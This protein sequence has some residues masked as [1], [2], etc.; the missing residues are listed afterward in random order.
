MKISEK[1]EDLLF[2]I[3]D[4]D[5]SDVNIGDDEDEILRFQI[6]LHGRTKDNRT[7]YVR[8]DDYTPYFYIEIPSQWRESHVNFFM[9]ALKKKV[10]Y[11][12]RCG[13][14]S[15][16]TVT[17]YKFVGFTNNKRFNFI[18]LMFHSY[19][20]FRSYGY[21]LNKPIFH[22][23]LGKK[24]KKYKAYESNVEPMLRCMHIQNLEAAGWV[25]IKG[26]NYK[27]FENN[28]TINNVN[29]NTKYY[30][31]NPYKDN[32]ILPLVIASFDIECTSGDG[33]FPQAWR[34]S[35]KI[36]QIGTT[37]SRYGESECFYRHIITLGSC[38]P[39]P[40][41]DVESYKTEGEVLLAW[42]KMIKKTNPDILTGYNIF[43]FDYK[44][45]RDRSKKLGVEYRFSKLCRD[46][47]SI[48]PF[49]TKELSSAAMGNNE[50]T[51]YKMGGR[52][53]IDLFKVV[54]RDYNLSSYKLDNVAAHF[55][56]EKMTD[57]VVTVIKKDNSRRTLIQTPNTDGLKVGGYITI[58][59]NDGLT[60]NKYEDG[61]KF[62]IIKLTKTSIKVMGKINKKELG[63]GKYKV[64]WCQAKDDVSPQDIFRLQK[65]S[66]A[67]RA[68]VARYCLQDCELVNKL[69]AKLQVITNNIGM[70]NVCNVPFS[71]LFLRGQGV[72]IFSLV[73]KKCREKNHVIPVIR[74]KN[75]EDKEKEKEKKKFTTYQVESTESEEEESGYEG[76]TVFVPKVG[77]HFEPIPVLDYASLYPSS[78]IHRNL[79]LETLV[80]DKIYLD[81][82]GYKYYTIKVRNKDEANLIN[83]L[84]SKQNLYNMFNNGEYDEYSE[85]SNESDESDEIVD[86]GFKLYTFA[87]KEDGSLGILPEILAYLL[88]AR[89]NTK[90]LMKSE[91][92]PFKKNIYNG[93]QLAYKITA[94][95]LYGQT[96]AL[97][98]SICCIP[99]AA[100]TTATGREMLNAARIFTEHMFYKIAEAIIENDYNLYKK[101]VN[102]L[103]NKKY[104]K[105]LGSQIMNQFNKNNDIDYLQ[106]FYEKEPIKDS[107]FVNEKLGHTCKEDFLKYFYNNIKTV[108][109]GKLIEPNTIY[110]DTDSVF[111][112]Y[113]IMDKVTLKKLTDQEGLEIAIKLGVYTGV[114][115]NFV[116]PYPHN[117][118]YEKTFWPFC[119]LTKKKY[120]GN[121]YEIDP[122]SYYQK[123]MGIVLKRRDNA[124]I[125]KIACGG[126]IDK[127]LNERSAKNA[128]KFLEKTLIKILSGKYPI[129]KFIIT[130]TL[131]AQYKYRERMVHAVLADRMAERD[132]GNKPQSNDRIPYVYYITKKPP[133]LQGDR[134]EHP[135]YLV[136]T[137]LKMDYLFY[138]TNQIMKPAIQFLELLIEN[139]QN[140]F[141]EY[142]TREQNRRKGIKPIKYLFQ[143]IK[144]NT[145]DENMDNLIKCDINKLIKHP[146]T[147][148]IKKRGGGKKK[149]K[150]KKSLE[151]KMNKK[152]DIIMEL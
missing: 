45:M 31:L 115:I 61:K 102:Y 41:V 84:N 82:P 85:E 35:D 15:F 54:Q 74:K 51:F 65:G 139:P 151:I 76:A 23:M 56:R 57:V 11:K 47:R 95:S 132:P 53:Q 60:D 106:I 78:M 1:H 58:Y 86:D 117:L 43:G 120:V 36:I 127:I 62:N 129:D 126:I 145:E 123:S 125:V 22:V 130:K 67:D 121:L 30:N 107:D 116:L 98:S 26:N 89:S 136:D 141:K 119:I 32:S 55:I 137:G 87:Q 39:I 135:K 3:V 50:L 37:F 52:I 81:M 143:S 140:I 42:T 101:R 66:S 2:Q 92:D 33:G 124:P 12:Y 17:K 18:R 150:V 49:I 149:R 93:L 19:K 21:A 108:L 8:V 96:G 64:Y 28:P 48:T 16:D 20:S 24:A 13:L 70:A 40:G 27:T 71:Y 72:K 14:K 46:P 10:W 148:N 73:A 91:K 111:L 80:L 88:K 5:S 105:L 59:Y 152:G 69:V 9:E 7:V 104:K 97:T 100:S 109:E 4:W 146:S 38:D 68:I 77:V 6:V 147:T 144:K 90:K 134:V 122:N 131:R 34:D 29:I 113:N 114:L 44:Y 94:N 118:E 128:V 63:F 99:I 142:I 83:K 110:G 79:S 75:K 133:K 112:N 138:I 103:F 25:S